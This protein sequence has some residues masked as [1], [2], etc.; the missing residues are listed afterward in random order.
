[1]KLEV[2]FT[3]TFSGPNSFDDIEDLAKW[4][5]GFED[6]VSEFTES[7]RQFI[8]AQPIVAACQTN[9]KKS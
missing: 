5:R 7:L 8:I 6:S 1:M 2:T 3:I 9:L 4:S